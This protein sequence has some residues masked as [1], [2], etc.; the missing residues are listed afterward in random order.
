MFF[1]IGRTKAAVLPEPVWAHAIKSPSSNDIIG[2][3][4]SLPLPD[5]SAFIS[6]CLLKLTPAAT[7]VNRVSSVSSTSVAGSF[8][9]LLASFPK[10][11]F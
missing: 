1:N 9:P 8:S 11:P 7:V 5:N 10:P 6:I 3:I 2:F 4:S